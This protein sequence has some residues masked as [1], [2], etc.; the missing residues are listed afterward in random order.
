MKTVVITGTN[1][2]IGLA[3]ARLFLEQGWRVFGTYRQSLPP[4]A[5]AEFIPIKLDLTDRRSIADAVDEIRKTTEQID[6]L[7]N[8]SGILNDAL[9]ETPDLSKIRQTFEV[10][11][12]GAIDLTE[13]LLIFFPEGGTIVNISSVYGSFAFPIDD[14]VSLGYRMSKAALNMYTRSLAYRL[15]DKNI[16]VSS[17][18]PGWVDTEMGRSVSTEDSHPNREPSDAAEDVYHLITTNKETGFFWHFGKKREW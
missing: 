5:S 10:N 13:R 2:G 4:I 14:G 17:L 9:D 15:K 6:A 8:N 11:V 12:F 1:K 7:V 18:H 16:V 3:T